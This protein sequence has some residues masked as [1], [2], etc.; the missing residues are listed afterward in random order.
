MTTKAKI[1]TAFCLLCSVGVHAQQTGDVF[2]GMF[3]RAQQFAATYP[4]EKTYLHLDNNSYY[5]GDTIWY[6]AYVVQAESNQPT[7]ISKPLYVELLDPLGNTVSRQIAEIKDGYAI[8]QIPLTNSFFSGYFELRAYTKWMLSAPEPQYYSRVLPI[9]RKMIGDKAEKRQIAEYNLEGGMQKRPKEKKE[10]KFSMRFFPEGGRL[11]KGI[12]CTVAF[13][14]VA[15]DS[16]SVNAE[17]SLYIG[18]ERQPIKALHD[19]IGTFRY[20]PSGDKAFVRMIY[21]GEEYQ[22]ELPKAEEQGITL[23]A[24]NSKDYIDVQVI[25]NLAAGSEANTAG[26]T[27]SSSC[28]VFFFAHGFPILYQKVDFKNQDIARF[29]V[30]SS[31]LPAGINRIALIS[32]QGKVMADRFCFVY[33]KDTLSLEAHTDTLVYRPFQKV[34]YQIQAKDQNGNPLRNATLSVSV[35]DALESDNQQYGDNIMTDLLLTSDLK[36]YIPNPAYYFIDRK[37]IR[38]R[39]LDNLLL[40]KGWRRYDVEQEISSASYTPKYLPEL[41]LTLHGRVKSLFGKPQKGIGV[42]VLAKKDSVVVAGNTNADDEGYFNMSLNM[43]EGEM[44]SYIQTRR[45]GKELNRWTNVSIFRNFEPQPRT[46]AYYETHPLWYKPQVNTQQLEEVD[47]AYKEQMS[48]D[49]IMLGEVTVKAKKKGNKQKETEHFER[50]IFGFYDVSRFIDKIRDEGKDVSLLENLLPQIDKNIHIEVSDSSHG[51]TINGTDRTYMYG[52]I[53]I[54]FYVN[55]KVLDENFFRKDLDAIK[56]ILIYEDNTLSNKE[57]YTMDKNFQVKRDQLKDTW[58]GD[59]IH[60]EN[61]LENQKAGIVCSVQ[62]SEDWNPEKTYKTHRGIRHTM[63]QGYN[64]P[65]T[66]YS[67]VYRDLNS[68]DPTDKRRTLYWN[69]SVTTDE[70]GKAIVECYNS[71]STAAVS[72]NAAMLQGGLTGYIDTAK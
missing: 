50:R 29:R 12:P 38:Q 20:T 32:S 19:G 56:S 14:T 46:L 18:E 7:Q 43:F 64:H 39:L 58:S 28:A 6:K 62:M 66:F 49:A 44:D 34:T 60:A 70:N 57:V 71:S 26:A 5:Q 48:K 30:S 36:G 24:T 51:D 4:Q 59:V 9:Y 63:L 68:F 15:T 22:F 55:G 25:R 45:Q 42:S 8:G 33:P 65:S 21:K 52:S 41:K 10:A 2:Q 17:G 72:L 67:P 54:T 69:P 31:Q 3:A 16:G 27:A 53:P 47:A 11:V 37:P 1:L 23:A 35:R 61:G 40:V 13:E